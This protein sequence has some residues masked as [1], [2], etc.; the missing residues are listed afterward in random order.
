MVC[1][2]LQLLATADRGGR[3]LS[4]KVEATFRGKPGKIGVSGQ[5]LTR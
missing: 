1:G 4:T 2:G 5:T 3:E